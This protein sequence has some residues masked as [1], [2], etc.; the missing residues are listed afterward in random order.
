MLFSAYGALLISLLL[1]R[2]AAMEL[3]LQRHILFL[4]DHSYLIAV[5]AFALVAPVVTAGIYLYGYGR[6]AARSRRHPAPGYSV[7]RDVWIV[8]SNAAVTIGRAVQIAAAMIILGSG[9][10]P[11]MFWVLFQE[12][13]RESGASASLVHAIG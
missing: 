12:L 10:I 1:V 5:V 9:S 2:Q 4:A 13:L 11:I 6:S 3:W 8:E 7:L